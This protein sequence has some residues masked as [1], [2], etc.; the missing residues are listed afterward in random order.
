MKA[1]NL[2]LCALSFSLLWAAPLSAQKKDPRKVKPNPQVKVELKKLQKHVM[3]RGMEDAAAVEV[4]RKLVSLTAE[5][6]RTDQAKTAAFLGK[7]LLQARRRP[8]DT[9]L[10]QAAADALSRLGPH[11]A[12]YLH[13]AIEA[14][15]FDD[16]EMLTFRCNMIRALGRTGETA[17][18]KPLLDLMQR[19]PHHK[20]NAAAVE[21]LGEYE[22]APLKDRKRI[23]EK[24]VKFFS[25]VNNNANQPTQ[26]DLVQETYRRKRN[27]ITGPCNNTLK[28]LTPKSFTKPLEWH[29]WYQNNK[30]KKWGEKGKKKE[31]R[32]GGRR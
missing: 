14:K 22:K 18:I 24:V 1:H 19:S 17:M 2:L 3:K 31:G 32:R 28:K 5:G 7:I 25:D 13:K 27:L 6:H 21:A 20:V 4:I 10:F 29:K 16:K 12:N 8:G 26:N 15:R 11:G 30:H 9:V 23:V